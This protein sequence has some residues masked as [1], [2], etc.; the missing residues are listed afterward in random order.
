VSPPGSGDWVVGIHNDPI[1]VDIEEVKNVNI[2][3]INKSTFSS[4]EFWYLIKSPKAKEI[5]ICGRLTKA[6]YSV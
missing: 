1:G 2:Y 4:K 6:G 5:E 3:E